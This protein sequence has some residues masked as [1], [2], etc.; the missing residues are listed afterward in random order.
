M[1]PVNFFNLVSA[2]IGTISLW[3]NHPQ[4]SLL[5]QMYCS[6]LSVIVPIASMYG[7]FTYIWFI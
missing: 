2:P 5:H 7:I 6:D 1:I 4:K 3:N